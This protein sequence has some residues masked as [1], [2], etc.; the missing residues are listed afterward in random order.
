[1]KFEPLMSIQSEGD[2]YIALSHIRHLIDYRFSSMDKQKILVSTS[3]LLR[4]ILDHAAATGDFTCSLVNK[5]ARTGLLVR[6]SDHGPGI[7]D[8]ETIL[9]GK[10]SGRTL[11]LG[12]G[13]SGVKRLMDEIDIKTSCEGTIIEVIKWSS[14]VS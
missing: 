1:L 4:N 6:V 2:I 3:E 11:G 7:I 14:R 8:V 10:S 9:Q 12:V 5:C 13:L